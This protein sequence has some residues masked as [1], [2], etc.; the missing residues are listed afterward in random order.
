MALLVLVLGAPTL[1]SASS[2]PSSH[3]SHPG[4]NGPAEANFTVST[5]NYSSSIDGFHLSYSEI[6]PLNYSSSKTY[7]LAI[8]LH[9]IDTAQ[10][11][12]Q[13]GGYPTPVTNTTADAAVADGF[14]LIVINTRTGDGYYVNS[15]YDGPQGQDVLDAI[16]H[17]ES[18][19]H[20]GKL[21]IFG[22]SMGSMGALSLGL[23][24]PGMFAGIGAVAA[25][26]DDFELE[27]RLIAAGNTP[28]E[29]AGLVPTGGQWPNSSAYAQ[30]I[31]EE[32]SP[33]RFHPTNA[34]GV[35]MW[36]AGGGLD[37]F[38]TNNL[39]FW[40]YEQ[41]N[42]TV[43]DSTC[44]V[45]S[46][47][48]EPANCTV[49]LAALHAED[50]AGYAYRYVWE[51][52]G[53]HDYNLLNA[54]DMFAFFLG[55]EPSGAYW[56]YFPDPTLLPQQVPLV[57][58]VTEPAG[59]GTIALNGTL[60]PSLES[61]P[62]HP[63]WVPADFLPCEGDVLG[64][65][66]AA[67]G[68]TYDASNGTLWVEDS[69]SLLVSF[70]GPLARVTF[71]ADTV[72]SSVLFNGAPEQADDVASIAPGTYLASAE[73][74][75][76]YT[77]SGWTTSGGLSVGN[78]S[79]VTTTVNVTGN[80]TLTVE[81]TE[82]GAP[83]P[84]VS[85]TIA[86]AP[87]SC[88][89]LLFDGEEAASGAVL[90]VEAGT[91]NISAPACSG[92]DFVA[93]SASGGV[94]LGAAGAT[95]AVTLR[96][97]GT[98]TA[99]YSPTPTGADATVTVMVVPSA[100]GPVVGVGTA[101]YANGSMF[102]VPLGSYSSSAGSCTGFTLVGWTSTGDVSLEPNAVDVQGNGTITATY[103]MN[104][105]GVNTG[106]CQGCLS[107]GTASADMVASL[108][109]GVAVGI[110]GTGVAVWARSRARK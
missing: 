95:V 50:P 92:Y 45:E 52:N 5:V 75:L 43:L 39:T 9:G 37:I 17:E 41:A 10:N 33:L 25:F 16:A 64:S 80:G 56:G 107:P 68:V 21:Y 44:L 61:V 13:E 86:S 79:S 11:T 32:L 71:S 90:T 65:V 100:C 78:A 60:Y 42:D 77:F 94:S 97:A 104:G 20:I 67:G 63:A 40:P 3:P 31:F 110:V 72:C 93:W 12:S 58:L 55:E 54:T 70:V 102:T 27:G 38:A 84:T 19:R 73:P 14:I 59:C 23:N 49:P 82:N 57:T 89:P 22:F 106:G 87:A 83:P 7:P 99:V 48:G 1:A 101:F 30:G 2:A 85:V 26:S 66:T 108:G 47:L 51:P 91:Y 74:C 29:E 96:S 36:I 76:G 28:L 62:I 81:F 88:G 53:F 35:R 24:H 15:K 34:S 8:E 103:S 18:I 6:L 109:I 98:L 69:G 46:D 105:G 4:V